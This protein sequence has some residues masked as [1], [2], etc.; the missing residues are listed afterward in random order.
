MGFCCHKEGAA[1]M[2][3]KESHVDEAPVVRESP[4]A[5]WDFQLVNSLRIQTLVRRAQQPLPTSWALQKDT[6]H[7]E[8]TQCSVFPAA[9]CT[10]G[11]LQLGFCISDKLRALKASDSMIVLFS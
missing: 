10:G 11:L 1:P 9:G 5:K 3:V 6:E 4:E 2:N 8:H 7:L